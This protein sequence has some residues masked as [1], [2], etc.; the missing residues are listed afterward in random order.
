MLDLLYFEDPELSTSPGQ[1]EGQDP[2]SF[3]EIEAKWSSKQ[4]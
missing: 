1:K 2:G 3:Q 4:I